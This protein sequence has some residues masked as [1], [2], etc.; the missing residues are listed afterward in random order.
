M[1]YSP[2]RT[3][4]HE[5]L[6][7][8]SPTQPAP[9][10][11]VEISNQV[12]PDK[13]AAR[14]NA[15]TSTAARYSKPGME[16]VWMILGMILMFVIPVAVHRPIMNALPDAPLHTLH[17][18]ASAINLAISVAIGMLIFVPWFMW[19]FIGSR[20][21]NSMVAEWVK[22]DQTTYGKNGAIGWRVKTPGVFNGRLVL[23]LSLPPSIANSLFH[24]NAYLPSFING[25]ADVEANHYYPF[26][27]EAG[28]GL[29][30]MSVV[31]NVPLYADEKTGAYSSIRI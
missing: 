17:A 19:K 11:P 9:L 16:R 18:Q 10:P 21:V 29:P 6:V 13:W 25:P 8:L 30:R 3:K 26:K 20:R 28:S 27:S 22:T 2:E 31:G 1:Y 7:Y 5:I 23:I 4:A 12:S 14:V 24:P 15:I